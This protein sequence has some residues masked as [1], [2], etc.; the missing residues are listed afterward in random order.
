MGHARKDIT[1]EVIGDLTAVQ[2]AFLNR[3][4]QWEW[5]WLCACG[6]TRTAVPNGLRN[7]QYCGRHQTCGRCTVKTGVPAEDLTGKPFGLWRVL[8]R[9]DKLDS[10]RSIYWLCRCECGAEHPVRGKHL[11][12]HASLCCRSCSARIRT[13]DMD[14]PRVKMLRLRAGL[15]IR[16]AA[17]MAGCKHQNWHAWERCRHLNASSVDNLCRVLGCRPSALVGRRVLA[18]QTPVG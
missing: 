1:G 17:K 8:E 7:E 14:G 11:V 9:Y 13:R 16:Q 12:H 4:G 2:R 3:F 18:T 15:T 6:K 5:L 10:S